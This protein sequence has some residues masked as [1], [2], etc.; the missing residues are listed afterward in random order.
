MFNR[1]PHLLPVSDRASLLHY[2]TAEILERY[3]VTLN[4][5]PKHNTHELHSCPVSFEN[6][7]DKEV[8]SIWAQHQDSSI[9][10]LL[11]GEIF[12]R[13][14]DKSLTPAKTKAGFH[15]TRIFTHETKF[16]R[17]NFILRELRWRLHFRKMMMYPEIIKD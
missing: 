4:C 12:S 9:T 1:R 13:L 16:H 5:D 17:L 15:S 2:P 10:E 14:W 8:L 6:Y 7:E 3:E 11:Y